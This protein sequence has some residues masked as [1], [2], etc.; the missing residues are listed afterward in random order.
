MPHV[1]KVDTPGTVISHK[2]S[3]GDLGLY[4]MSRRCPL[5]VFSYPYQRRLYR[6]AYFTHL[7]DLGVSD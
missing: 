6:A 7:G 2:S 4:P 3:K 5:R 1:G